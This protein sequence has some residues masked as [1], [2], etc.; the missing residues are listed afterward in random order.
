MQAHIIGVE[1]QQVD[2]RFPPCALGSGSASSPSTLFTPSA[3]TAEGRGGAEDVLSPTKFLR[4][5][6]A[7]AFDPL[8]ATAAKFTRPS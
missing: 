6:E 3:V 8:P 7:S 4:G 1:R 5:Q 2:P